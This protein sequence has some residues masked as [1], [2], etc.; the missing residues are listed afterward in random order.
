MRNA[1]LIERKE[2]IHTPKRIINDKL[3]MNDG[4]FIDWYYIDTPKSVIIVPFNIDS[5]LVMV[6]QYRYNLKKFTLEFPSGSVNQNEKVEEAAIRELIEE[7]GFKTSVEF[8]KS[9]GHFY[10]LPS[11]TNRY[12]TILV[13]ES[14][15]KIT[16]PKHDKIIEKYFE[17]QTVEL[18]FNKAISEI[19]RAIQGIETISALLLLKETLKNDNDKK[20]I[21]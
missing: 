17:M 14:V 18:S 7:T 4:T 19:G 21:S 13:A 8:M 20:I 3:Q 16:E 12:V 1:K 11:E 10:V 5:K 2:I 15:K 6:K 9:I